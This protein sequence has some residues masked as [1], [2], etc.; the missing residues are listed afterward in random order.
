MRRLILILLILVPMAA[1]A[2]ESS[3]GGPLF[4]KDMLGVREFFDPW[5]VGIDIFSMQQDYGI[6]SLDFQLPGVEIGDASLI[7]V[8]NDLQSYDLKFDA[9]ITPFLN[10]FALVGRLKADTYVDFSKLPIQGLPFPLSAVQVSYDGT[11]YGAGFN[12]IY[13]TDK[14]FVALNNTWTDASLSGDFDSSVSAYTAQPRIGLIRD[15]WT[16]YAGGMYLDTQEKHSGTIQL[17]IPGFPPVPFKVELESAE[18]WNYAVGVMH[19]FSPKAQVL[20]EYGFGDRTHTLLNFT[21]RF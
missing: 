13:G 2:Q 14:W 12:L 16:F 15:K 20:L 6:V 19:V 1:S 4:M 5:G 7:G 21:Y 8:T 9:W 3:S 17:P 11:V 18:N 10:V